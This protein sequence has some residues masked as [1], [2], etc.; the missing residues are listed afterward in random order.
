MLISLMDPLDTSHLG[1]RVHPGCV[2][3]VPEYARVTKPVDGGPQ[4]TA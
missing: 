4:A 1:V 3:D 2:L